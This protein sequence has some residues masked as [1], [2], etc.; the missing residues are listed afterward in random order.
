MAAFVTV[1]V[2]AILPSACAYRAEREAPPGWGITLVTREV[3][4]GRLPEDV[5][6]DEGI[7]SI[8]PDGEHVIC[9]AR[10]DEKRIVY[11]DG[12]EGKQFDGIGSPGEMEGQDP[13]DILFRVS[14]HFT[15][16]AYVAVRGEKRLVVLDGVEGREYD[17]IHNIVFS[18]DSKRLGYIAE[19]ERFVPEEISGVPFGLGESKFLA[20]VDGLEGKEYDGVREFVFSP[21]SSRVA[22]VAKEGEHEFL[23]LDGQE[24]E[25]HPEIW[26]LCF[27]PDS[28]RV[29]YVVGDR[30]AWF[31][32]ESHEKTDQ[33]VVVDGVPGN[34]YQC[35]PFP[36]FSVSSVGTFAGNFAPWRSPLLFSPD[37]RHIAYLAR[38]EGKELLVVD[39]LELE[40]RR[41]KDTGAAD[42]LRVEVVFSP[43][44]AHMAYT[45]QREEKWCV[46]VNG[47]QGDLCDRVGD[48]VF[49]PDSAHMAY[50]AQREKKWCV[51]ADGVQGDLY[52]CV[53]NIVF[54]PD[55]AR[56][57]YIGT[58]D[59]K[60]FVVLGEEEGKAYDWVGL[61][62]FGPG[63]AQH[64]AYPAR[65][66]QRWVLV[67]DGFESREFEGAHC[68]F[69]ANFDG[70]ASLH[71]VVI[72]NRQVVRV[73]VQIVNP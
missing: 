5:H 67:V 55:S 17:G 57:A 25:R 73:E 38:S 15:R 63:G 3:P 62:L 29:A 72:R 18:P 28:K 35:I 45:A 53:S 26:N 49:S 33:F 71:A 54:S 56:L 50:I 58:R 12:T 20:V 31:M 68:P 32:P 69:L 65:R 34:T 59:G 27:S 61:P 48:I 39:G 30:F 70:P 7:V 36:T 41:T 14:E 47:A 4:L 10:R 37:S 2:A 11:V 66:G 40:V 22:Y 42:D 16:V 52:E 51:V 60:E 44:S 13:W 43:D 24:G 8:S 1:L 6:P 9:V 23:V 21:D 46:I 64:I 19:R